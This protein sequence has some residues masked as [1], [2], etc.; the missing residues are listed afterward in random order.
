LIESEEV[1]TTETSEEFTAAEFGE[2]I[3]TATGIDVDHIDIW[4]DFKLT[5]PEQAAGEENAE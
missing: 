4:E 1:D 5:L 3:E 2:Q